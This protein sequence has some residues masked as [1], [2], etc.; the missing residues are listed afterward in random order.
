[1]KTVQAA[2]ERETDKQ[3]LPD[4]DDVNST[5]STLRFIAVSATI[6]NI[7]DVGIDFKIILTHMKSILFLFYKLSQ[8]LDFLTNFLTFWANCKFPHQL[9]FF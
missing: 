5:N 4:I 2:V 7:E 6:P 1:M 8:M 9:I 3:Q